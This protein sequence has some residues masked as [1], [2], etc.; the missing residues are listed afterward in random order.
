MRHYRWYCAADQRPSPRLQQAAV[1]H[2]G[3][4]QVRL[5]PVCLLHDALHVLRL[6][7][8]SELQLPNVLGQ[9]ALEHGQDLLAAALAAVH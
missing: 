3:R 5:V 6:Q 4:N 9:A 7:N 8:L 1:A 2:L